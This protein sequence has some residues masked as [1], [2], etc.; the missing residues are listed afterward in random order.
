MG[1]SIF[2]VIITATCGDAGGNRTGATAATGSPKPL[3]SGRRVP[4]GATPAQGTGGAPLADGRSG[5]A[6][7]GRRLR[8]PGPLLP[9]RR[10]ICAERTPDGYR[11]HYEYG[12]FATGTATAHLIRQA[13]GSF[14]EERPQRR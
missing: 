1:K 8:S 12:G 5:S 10:L 13:D 6:V 11:V 2:L 4:Q 3:W 9:F 14:V 7:P